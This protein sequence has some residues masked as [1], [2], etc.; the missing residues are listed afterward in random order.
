MSHPR[1]SDE[2]AS[3]VAAPVVSILVAL[4]IIVLAVAL[5]RLGQSNQVD[6]TRECLA[7]LDP[8]QASVRELTVLPRIGETM[9]YRIV[10]YRDSVQGAEGSGMRRPA[11]QSA[12]DMSLVRGIGPVT[13]Q[14]IAPHVRFPSDHISAGSNSRSRA[15]GLSLETP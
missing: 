1:R 15:R 3:S 9:A 6:A 12:S 7:G 11:F 4:W 14:R 5:P 8:N 2:A 13:V 10:E